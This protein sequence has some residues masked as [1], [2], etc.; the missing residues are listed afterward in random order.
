M[1]LKIL[2]WNI[3]CD[4]YFDK[5]TEFL[6]D[7]DADIIGLQEV[8]PNDPARDV[9]SYLAK[10][11]YH[12][13]LAPVS[14]IQRDGRSMGNAVFS[15]YEIAGTAAYALSEPDDRQTGRKA[16]RADI[17]IGE[18]TLHVI[19]THLLHTHQRVSEIQNH[20][21]ANLIKILPAEQTVVM[22][23]FNALPDSEVIRKMSAALVNTDP[24]LAPTAFLYA[25]GCSV[26][27]IAEIKI[28][29][30]YIFATPDLKTGAPRV[31]QSAGSD[32]LPISVT[33][34]I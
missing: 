30:D 27:R 33:L 8:V 24:S 19:S 9:I 23:D 3:W 28:R 2:S 25:A 22:G 21:V 16:V 31:L 29:L 34:E 20:Q 1:T 12:Q 10:L 11:G 32:H 7:F 26:C 13:A 18:T 5:I 15:K 4:G 14:K 6:A 17:K